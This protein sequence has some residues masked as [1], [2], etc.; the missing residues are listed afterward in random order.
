[1]GI[2]IKQALSTMGAKG[3]RRSTR[4]SVFHI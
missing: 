3:R 4:D 1:L 2:L